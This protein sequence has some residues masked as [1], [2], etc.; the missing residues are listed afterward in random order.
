MSPRLRS[1]GPSIPWSAGHSPSFAA[2]VCPRSAGGIGSDSVW[3]SPSRSTKAS[4]PAA[5][6]LS[7]NV[8]VPVA[9]AT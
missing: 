9:A 6:P 8:C 1:Y 4:Q 2:P 7:R 3:R 5:R